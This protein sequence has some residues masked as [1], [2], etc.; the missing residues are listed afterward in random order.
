VSA[1]A[2]TGSAEQWHEEQDRSRH[3][4]WRDSPAEQIV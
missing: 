1:P 2:L 3:E 4:L